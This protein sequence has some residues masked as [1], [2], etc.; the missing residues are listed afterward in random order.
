MT[1]F[2]TQF[3]Q[4]FCRNYDMIPTHIMIYYTPRNAYKWQFMQ[5]YTHQISGQ[6]TPNCQHAG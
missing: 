2:Y 3:C 1:H 5:Q 6:D 4:C